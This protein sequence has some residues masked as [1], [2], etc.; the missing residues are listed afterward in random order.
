[1]RVDRAEGR[2]QQ[3]QGSRD[4]GEVTIEA[5]RLRFFL[6]PAFIVPVGYAVVQLAML[7]QRVWLSCGL[8]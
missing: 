4:H 2:T 8:G 6:L 1:M 5:R 3:L 7:L